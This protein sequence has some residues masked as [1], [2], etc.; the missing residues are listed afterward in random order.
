MLGQQ[1][2]VF[3]TTLPGVNRTIA[4]TNAISAGRFYVLHRVGGQIRLTLTLPGTLVKSGGTTLKV[5]YSST[6]A[7]IRTIGAG[8]TTTAFNPGSAKTYSY[9]RSPDIYVQI[10]GTIQPKVNQASGTYLGTIT[11]TVAVLQ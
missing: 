9:T 11:L 3:G 10:G 6:A 2:L 8:A 5:V 4:P 1:G 7:V